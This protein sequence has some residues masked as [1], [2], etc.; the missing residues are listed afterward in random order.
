ME[1]E[2]CSYRPY[3]L[4]TVAYV[5]WHNSLNTETLDEPYS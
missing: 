5:L 4:S 2:E 1:A 3:R